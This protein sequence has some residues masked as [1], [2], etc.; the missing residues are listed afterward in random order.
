MAE[1]VSAN[2]N[3]WRMVNDVWDEWRDFRNLMD[4]APKWTS[5]ISSGTWPDCD[6]IPLGK[7]SVRGKRD[8]RMTKLTRDEQYSLMTLFTICRSPLMFGG[9]MPEND[10]FT[11][12]LLTNTEVLKMHRESTGNRL[13]VKTND[14]AIWTAKNSK[15]ADVYL[16]LF[17]ISDNEGP[18]EV[19]VDLKAMGLAEKYK[20]VDLWSSTDIGFVSVGFTQEIRAHACGLYKF[21]KLKENRIEAL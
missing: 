19:T 4:V 14:Y 20:V 2:V 9:N 21:L 7:L 12:S 15:T 1:H 5:Y 13:V 10:N 3:M 16:A 11:N 6:M 8:E 17:N 18:I